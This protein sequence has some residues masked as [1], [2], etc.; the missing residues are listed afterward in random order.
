MDVIE[1]TDA[2]FNEVYDTDKPFLVDFWAVWCGPCRMMAPIVEDI[3]DH[4]NGKLKVGRL[5]VDNEIKIANEF[6]I[7]SIP[8]FIIFINGKEKERIVG[9]V[10]KDF[11]IEKLDQYL[12]SS[13]AKAKTKKNLKKEKR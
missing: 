7:Q 9:A 11:L 2:T 12:Q 10:P 5:N 4:Y 3:A 13:S 6:G 1:L 8:T